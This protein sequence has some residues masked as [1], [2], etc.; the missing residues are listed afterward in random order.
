[1]GKWSEWQGR[2]LIP[3]TQTQYTEDQLCCLQT[4]VSAGWPTGSWKSPSRQSYGP[5][6]LEPPVAEHPT[7]TCRLK[8]MKHAVRSETALKNKST[9]D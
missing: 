7:E 9:Q 4:G 6:L 1:M 5:S 8:S 3:D 2:I